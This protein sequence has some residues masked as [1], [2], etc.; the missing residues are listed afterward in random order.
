MALQK[1]EEGEWEG[2]SNQVSFQKECI[3][4]HHFEGKTTNLICDSTI[5]EY[6]YPRYELQITR[7]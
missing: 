6:M 7:K 3:K 4:G 1:E 2:V 5:H